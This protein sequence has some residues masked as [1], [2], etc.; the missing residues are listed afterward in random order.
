[1]N[2]TKIA[3]EQFSLLTKIIYEPKKRKI[4]GQRIVEMRLEGRRSEELEA[5]GIRPEG[6]SPSLVRLAG[7]RT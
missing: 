1:M 6:S 7:G 3:E 4:L 2:I 5:D